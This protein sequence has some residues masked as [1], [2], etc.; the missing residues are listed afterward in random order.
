MTCYSLNS[1]ADG[2][3]EHGSVRAWCL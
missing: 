1:V 3:V 2:K